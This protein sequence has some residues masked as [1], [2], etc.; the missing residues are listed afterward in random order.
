MLT[1]DGTL[2]IEAP[3]MTFVAD[4]HEQAQFFAAK[5]R[6]RWRKRL[7][8]IIAFILFLIIWEAF[9]RIFGVK[10]YIAPAPSVVATLIVERFGMLMRNLMPTAIETFL[11]F[12]VGNGFAV[13]LAILFV[14]RRTAEEAL[15]P[16]AVMV[17]TVPIVAVA[18][19]LVLLL[20][21]GLEPKVAIAALV[22]FFPTLVNVARGL[23]AVS[24]EHMEL[25]HVLSASE[26]EVFIKVRFANSIPY[27]FAALKIAASTSVI[28]AIVGE[29]IG[30]THGIGAVI[31]QAAYN[32]DSPLLYAA[33]AVGSIFS[34]CFF[35][36]VAALERKFVRWRVDADL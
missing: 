25:M 8:P 5:R 29:W 27:L 13:G 10:A 33:V 21:N 17:N 4:V 9:V 12:L 31:L 3:P 19:I 23:R 34:A 28:G 2:H 22:C 6:L 26:R 16:L 15:F 32:F 36:A 1:T 20:G 14:Y 35:G 18:P 7:L 11:G 24:H 30:A